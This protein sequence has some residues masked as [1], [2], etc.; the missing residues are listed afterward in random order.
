MDPTPIGKRLRELR[1]GRGIRQSDL[2]RQMGISPAY[3]NLLEKGRRS[4]KM[5]LLLSALDALSVDLD[6]FM[7]G[8]RDRQP[9]DV[10]AEL[11]GDPLADTLDLESEDIERARS[12]PR[13]ATTIAALFHLYKNTRAQL[14]RAVSSLEAGAPPPHGYAPGDEVTD[15]LEA[16]KNYFPELEEDAAR[17]RRDAALP[18][19]FVSEQ[20]ADVLRQRFDLRVAVESPPA[21]TSVVRSFDPEARSLRVSSALSENALKFQLAHVV[22][23]M[24]LDESRL[25]ERLVAEAPPRHAETLRLIKIHLANYFAGA[26]LLP[27]DEFFDEVQRT[28]YD[29]ERIA[30]SFESSFEAVAHRMCNL[31]DPKRPGVPLHFLRVDVAGNISKRYSASGLRFSHGHGS[32][33]KWAV[34]AAFLTPATIAKQYSMMPS[35]DTYFCAARVL[36]EPLAGSAVRGSTYSIGVGCAAE[37]AHHLVYADDLPKRDIERAAVPVGMSCR[38]CER[39]DCNQRAAPSYKFAFAVDEYTKKENFFSPI[40]GADAPYGKKP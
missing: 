3:L 25:H 17:V 32:C 1:L 31:A 13:L 2:A 15:F 12:E 18:R 9:D 30:S 24:L 33:P 26:L 29:I 39:T 16:N 22:G 4:I 23:L 10:L 28:R 36:S 38:F 21:R 5:P 6:A 11:L 27:Y 35:G 34:H 20:L 7:G 37:D 40:T 8:V 14:D 19:R